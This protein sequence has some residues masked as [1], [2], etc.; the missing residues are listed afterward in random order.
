VAIVRNPAG[1]LGPV[2]RSITPVTPLADVTPITSLLP[3][4]VFDVETS[5][6]AAV[7]E[8]SVD[9]KKQGN[10]TEA[11]T[12]GTNWSFTW[13]LGTDAATA[14][15]ADGTYVIGAQAYDNNNLSGG[16][17]TRTMVI[18]RFS[19]L[20]VTGIDG[21][22]RNAK[23]GG[24][25]DLDWIAN[26]E[27]DIAGYRV[28]D[29]TT[30]TLANRVCPPSSDGATAV[31]GSKVTE[32]ADES[33]TTTQVCVLPLVCLALPISTY[34][35]V[36]LDRDGSSNPREGAATGTIAVDDRANTSRPSAPASL[37]GCTGG[38]AGCA[39]GSGDVALTWPAASDPDGDSI[40]FYRVYRNG[41]RYGRLYSGGSLTYVD[42][43][44]GATTHSYYV[45]AVDVNYAESTASGSVTK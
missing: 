28:Y 34:T 39:A 18:N 2:V 20:G 26:K 25:V 6:D 45:T 42:S 10:A 15:V 27:R 38:A 5:S 16:P 44:T 31:L 24:P 23:D 13:T 22:W 3:L 43:G 1:G 30:L 21:G 17:A 11:G 35:V 8:W 7:V 12:G 14:P 4:I 29:G 41:A 9:G 37:T 32:C 36:A 19:P 40:G 33:P